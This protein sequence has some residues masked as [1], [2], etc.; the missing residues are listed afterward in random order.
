MNA[1]WW[2]SMTKPCAG[3]LETSDI[4]RWYHVDDVSILPQ[5]G[6]SIILS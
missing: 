1:K 6:T 5:T 2:R 3:S 4:F